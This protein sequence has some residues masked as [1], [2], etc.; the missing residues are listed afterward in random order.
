MSL[1]KK[2]NIHNKNKKSKCPLFS[3]SVNDLIAIRRKC[4]RYY[5]FGPKQTALKT[6]VKIHLPLIFPGQIYL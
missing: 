1:S 6:E 4:H 2:S 3:H 5:S